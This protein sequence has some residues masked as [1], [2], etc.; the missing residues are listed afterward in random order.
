MII[1]M[2][3]NLQNQLIYNVY[4]VGLGLQTEQSDITDM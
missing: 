3:I 1:S 4:N 2:S